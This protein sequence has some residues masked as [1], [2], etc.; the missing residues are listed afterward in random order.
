VDIEVC[1]VFDRHFFNGLIEALLLVLAS[2]FKTSA[3]HSLIN[4]QANMLIY[5]LFTRLA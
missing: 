1:S 2:R 4:A 3:P 5:G